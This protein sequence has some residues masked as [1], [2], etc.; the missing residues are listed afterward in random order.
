MYYCINCSEIHNEKNTRDKIFKN[1]FYIDPFLGE[2]YHL[3]MCNTE[4]TQESQDDSLT[5][6]EYPQTIM[7]D[8]PIHI[9]SP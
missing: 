2:M 8:L 1:G 9:T 7:N 6:T 4:I 5:K 3:G